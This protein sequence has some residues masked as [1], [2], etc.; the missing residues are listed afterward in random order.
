MSAILNFLSDHHIV[1]AD[2]KEDKPPE[3]KPK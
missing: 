1:V 2:D 3:K